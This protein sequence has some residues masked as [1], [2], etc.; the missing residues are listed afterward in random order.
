MLC[1]VFYAV[2]VFGVTYLVTR[3][4]FWTIYG[5]EPGPADIDRWL[6]RSRQRTRRCAELGRWFWATI[7]MSYLLGRKRKKHRL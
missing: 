5:T 6:L 7:H 3:E 2:T 4:E 1:A